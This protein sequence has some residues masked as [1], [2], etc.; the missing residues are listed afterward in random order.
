MDEIKNSFL[1]HIIFLLFIGQGC[2][3][4]ENKRESTSERELNKISGWWIYGE[5]QHIFKDEKTLEEFDLFFLNEDSLALIDLYLSITE[6]EYFPM[7]VDVIGIH[8][9]NKVF[10][11]HDFEITYIKG[12]D[13]Q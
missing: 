9:N 6:M 2:I 3:S 7:E 11:V 12:C 13:E 4:P 1:I 5:G 10:S 8:N